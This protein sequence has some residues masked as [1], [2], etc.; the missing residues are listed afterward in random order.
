[1]QVFVLGAPRSGTTVVGNFIASHPQCSDLGEYYG[2]Y[3]TLDQAPRLMQRM[4]TPHRDAFLADLFEASVG[5]AERTLI[6]GRSFWCDHTPHNLLVASSLVARFPSAVFILMLRHYRGCIQSLRRSYAEGYPWAGIRFMDSAQ[7]WADFYE[8][9]DALPPDRTLPVSYDALCAEPGS[10]VERI[11]SFLADRVGVA[12]AAFDHAIF[13]SS[14][15]TKTSR[16]TLATTDGATTFFR[17]KSSFDANAWGD[18]YE[19]A[20][21]IH[22]A[23]VDALLRKRYPAV[24]REATSVPDC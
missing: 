15:A 16:P 12:A 24:Y 5:F 20:A 1:M 22:V 17:R 4:P 10:E 3:L 19:A 13:A 2:F 21:H 23:P 6:D 14:H 8:R 9:V 7:L 18:G 11:T